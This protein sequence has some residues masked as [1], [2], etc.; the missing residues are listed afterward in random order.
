MT[1]GFRDRCTPEFTAVQMATVKEMFEWLT[2]Q[3]R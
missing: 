2:S 3:M 1:R